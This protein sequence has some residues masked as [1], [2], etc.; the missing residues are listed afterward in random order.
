LLQDI[1][2]KH[3]NNKSIKAEKNNSIFL[4]SFIFLIIFIAIP[5]A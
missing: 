4:K 5:F 2:L 3:K 1:K